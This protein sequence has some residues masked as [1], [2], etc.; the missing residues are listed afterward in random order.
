[1]IGIRGDERAR[2]GTTIVKFCSDAH[3]FDSP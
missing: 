3:S 1:M 2:R